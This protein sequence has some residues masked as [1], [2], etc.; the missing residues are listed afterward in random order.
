MNLQKIRIKRL[1]RQLSY[2]GNVD[3]DVKEKIE[4]SDRRTY[5][6]EHRKFMSIKKR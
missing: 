5:E 6:H 3:D 1:K 2:R 4:L